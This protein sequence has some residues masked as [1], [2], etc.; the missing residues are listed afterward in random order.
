MILT[1]INKRLEEISEILPKGLAELQRAEYAYQT[2]FSYLV[3]HSGMGNAQSREAEA[4]LVCD[5]EGLYSPLADLRGQC[6][7]LQV[8]KDCLMEISR[9]IRFVE[10]G[11]RDFHKSTK[12][13]GE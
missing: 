4:L 12:L 5:Q 7:G 1:D 3:S 11:E 9:N 13:G 2:R 6:R 8:E 10:Q